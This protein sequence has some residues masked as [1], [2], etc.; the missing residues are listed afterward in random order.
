MVEVMNAQP[1]YSNLATEGDYIARPEH[2]PLTKFEAR[3]HRLGHGVW[4]MMYQR[5]I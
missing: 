1:G 4:D 3:G 2:R 5:T